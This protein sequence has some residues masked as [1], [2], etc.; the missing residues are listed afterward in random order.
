MIQESIAPE[1]WKHVISEENPADVASRGIM[2]Y[3]LKSLTMW[4]NGPD[5]LSQEFTPPPTRVEETTEEMRKPKTLRK[6]SE[7]WSFR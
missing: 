1:Q 6:T 3:E 2:P 5:W 7:T 4:F